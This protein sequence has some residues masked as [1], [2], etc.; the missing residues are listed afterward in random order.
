MIQVA[1]AMPLIE[2]VHQTELSASR[3]RIYLVITLMALKS[4]TTA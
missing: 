3:H 1:E 4:S 2:T